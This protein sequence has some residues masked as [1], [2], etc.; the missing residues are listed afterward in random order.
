MNAASVIR[1]RCTRLLMV[2]SWQPTIAA[3]S[4]Q[5]KPAAP[6]IF[7]GG[8]WG[9]ITQ[10]RANPANL[11]QAIVSHIHIL[12][13]IDWKLHR[14]GCA[15]ENAMPQKFL[16]VLAISLVLI[17]STLTSSAF[18]RGDRYGR[19][20]QCNGGDDGCHADGS[21]GRR[22]VWGYSG[23]YYGPMVPAPF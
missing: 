22:D 19:A 18:A 5:L 20:V 21:R 14:I 23:A 3:A 15:R 12:P 7:V 13:D 10:S 16:P 4:S 9:A 2:L 8:T 11:G 17:S 6:T 1:A